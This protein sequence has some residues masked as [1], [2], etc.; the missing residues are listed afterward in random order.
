MTMGRGRW[1]GVIVL[2][3]AMGLPSGGAVAETK[4]RTD[5][6]G[7]APSGID[8]ATARYSH[9][10]R[11]V[12]VRATIPDL[13]PHG[14]ASL[15]VTRFEVFEAGYVV[16][17][18]KRRS[19]APRTRLL[20]FDHFDT[21]KRRCAGVSGHWGRASIRLSVPLRCLRGHQEP[22]VFVQFASSDGRRVDRAP[23]V[24]RLDQD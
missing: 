3:V 12:A 4:T 13:Q 6:V 14:T 21:T 15:S 2:A 11:R 8:V 22:E 24:R 20:F 16:E 7:D 9:T 19:R 23:A 5:T 1:L 10:S 17:I 18:V